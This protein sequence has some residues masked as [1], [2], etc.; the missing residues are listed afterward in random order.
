MRVNKH[1]G[2]ACNVSILLSFYNHKCC[3]V[4]SDFSRTA[5]SVFMNILFIGF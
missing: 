4:L 1:G 3:G 5:V 2:L